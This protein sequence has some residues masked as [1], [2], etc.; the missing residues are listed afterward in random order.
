MIALVPPAKY[1]GDTFYPGSLSSQL[2]ILWGSHL[3]DQSQAVQ[4][5]LG[6]FEEV[7]LLLLF[8]RTIFTQGAALT[9]LLIKVCSIGSFLKDS[10]CLISLFLL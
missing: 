9:V 7:T 10:V 2:L 4:G 1:R 3:G 5:F 6:Y 8:D